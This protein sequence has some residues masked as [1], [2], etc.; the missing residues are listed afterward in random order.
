[1]D[2][3]KNKTAGGKVLK[4]YSFWNLIFHKNDCGEFT[5]MKGR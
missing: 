4:R 3:G 2:F 5:K 1:M